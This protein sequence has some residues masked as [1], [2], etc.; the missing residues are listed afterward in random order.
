M[1]HNKKLTY[2][3]DDDGQSW[4]HIPG[5]TRT[6][7]MDS[8]MKGNKPAPSTMGDKDWASHHWICTLRYGRRQFTVNFWTGIGWNRKP[9]IGDVL[10]CLLSD[11]TGYE[12]SRDFEDWASQFGFDPDSRRAYSIYQAVK[13][14][15][16]RLR[17]LLGDELYE[18]ALW[19]WDHEFEKEGK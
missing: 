6:I 7:R 10:Y 9:D 12:N 16:K 13:R 3:V 17:R 18:V 14:Q 4:L 8:P 15:S 19:E 5:Q 1:S 2:T 11:A